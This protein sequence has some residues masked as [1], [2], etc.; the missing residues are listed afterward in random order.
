[1]QSLLDMCQYICTH[2][3]KIVEKKPDFLKENKA[4]ALRMQKKS[5]FISDS[6]LNSNLLNTNETFTQPSKP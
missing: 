6:T 2:I 5:D 1:M 3:L 4:L